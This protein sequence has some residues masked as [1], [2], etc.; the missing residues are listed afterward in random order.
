MEWA[1]TDFARLLLA[2]A[3]PL[4]LASCATGIRPLGPSGAVTLEGNE[5]LLILHVDTDIPISA[6]ELN[7][8]TIASGVAPGHFAWVVRAGAGSY[9]FTSLRFLNLP[10]HQRRRHQESNWD[11]LFRP[12]QSTKQQQTLHLGSED[13]FRFIVEPGSVN[14]GGAL[15]VRG[16][17]GA[18]EVRCRNHVAMA[19]RMLSGRD[20]ELVASHPLRYGG[21]SEDGFLDYYSRERS[22]V[23]EN[24]P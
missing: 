14:Y 18:I 23:I 3:I 21:L 6:I 1:L 12:L 13:E 9:R 4:L 5:G 16:N 11:Y 7:G 8:K 10:G 15:V 22:A 19:I 20:A 17:S 24:E 2:T